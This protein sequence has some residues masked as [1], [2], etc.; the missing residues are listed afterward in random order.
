MDG[1]NFYRLTSSFQAFYSITSSAPYAANVYRL[2]ARCDV[3]NNSSGTARIVYLKVRFIG[4]YTDPGTSV[5]DTILTDD[6]IDGTFLVTVTEKRASGKLLPSG[7]F[8]VSRPS[9]SISTLTGT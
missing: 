2:E 1:Q 7:D 9:Y 8:T 5:F 3:S 6:E 4:G